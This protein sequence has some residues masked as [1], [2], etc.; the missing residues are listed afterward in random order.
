M[1][2][3]ILMPG[4]LVMNTFCLLAIIMLYLSFVNP[5]LYLSSRGGAF[6]TNALKT[7]LSELN[8][9]RYKVVTFNLKHYNDARGICGGTQMDRGIAAKS[10]CLKRSYPKYSHCI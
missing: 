5:D 3:R 9:K 10:R 8:E 6:N 1:I 7:K 4:Y 2:V